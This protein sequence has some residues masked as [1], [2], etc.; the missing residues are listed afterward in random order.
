MHIPDNVFAFL[1]QTAAKHARRVILF[2]S[3]ARGDC[4]EKS[5]ID[6]AFWGTSQG[7]ASF[8]CALDEMPTLLEWDCVH[9][10]QHTSAELLANIQK[11][12]VVIMD[13]L[14]KRIDQLARAIDRLRDAVAEYNQT[15][16]LAVRDGVIQRFEFCTELAWKSAQD[17]LENEGFLDVH[18][19]KAIMRKA[20]LD[21]LVT[22]EQGWLAL[23]TA[24]NQTSHL[25]DDEV[26]AQVF[27][28][29]ESTYLPLLS[30]LNEQLHKSEP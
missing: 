21:G 7:Y 27:A 4:N 23:L 3:R 24:R 19:P 6:L 30:A 10:T 29:I 20:F 11:D 15:Q 14:A 18:S 1:C 26:A 16:S 5:D 17:Y 2:G 25:Y 8:C 13:A 9:I 28:D 22:D 12:G